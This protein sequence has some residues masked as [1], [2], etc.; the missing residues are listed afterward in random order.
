[1]RQLLAAAA[2]DPPLPPLENGAELNQ[3]TAQDDKRMW[4]R[5]ALAL[6]QRA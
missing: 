2:G 5:Q 4:E 6:L 1:M 3:L